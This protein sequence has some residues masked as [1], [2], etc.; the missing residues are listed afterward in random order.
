MRHRKV[1][2]I[3]AGGIGSY[4]IPILNR[5]GVYQVTAFDDDKVEQ[6]NLRYQNFSADDLGELKVYCFSSDMGGM[7]EAQP[8]LVL[9]EKQLQGYDLVICCADNLAVRKMLYRANVKW[10]D[11]R[12]QA[13]NCA[14][15][16]GD[17]SPEIM[18]TVLAGPDGSYSC[19]GQ[20]WDGTP[21]EV[22]FMQVVAAGL[23]A[24]WVQNHFSGKD[25]DNH[26]VVYA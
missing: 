5:L 18:E 7:Y 22:N 11:L 10:L 14:L 1:L 2:L 17:V 26:K 16:S 23:G 8:Y 13:R 20:G 3:G 19:Q 24:Q 15:I 25:V 6:K 12:A 9:T 4:L 21:E